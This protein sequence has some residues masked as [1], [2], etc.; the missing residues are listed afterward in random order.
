[1]TW[2]SLGERVNQAKS[3]TYAKVWGKAVPLNL[4]GFRAGRPNPSAREGWQ[5][6]ARSRGLASSRDGWLTDGATTTGD[7]PRLP[8][9]AITVPARHGVS[10]RHASISRQHFPSGPSSHSCHSAVR[11]KSSTM[12]SWRSGSSMRSPWPAP[13]VL[14]SS[15]RSR[16]RS[17]GARWWRG[18]VAHPP[19]RPQGEAGATV[20][21]EAGRDRLQ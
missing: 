12:G 17:H 6:P 11:I 14:P 13:M 18:P 10:R 16:I 20:G 3:I 9:P 8:L 19:Q 4:N 5:A 21:A 15:M 7:S 1:M 2:R